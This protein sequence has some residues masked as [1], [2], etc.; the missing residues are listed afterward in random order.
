MRILFLM[1]DEGSPPG[2]LLEETQ[3]LG[4]QPSVLVP[5]KNISHDLELPGSVPT[6]PDGF[7]GLV[8]LG[9]AMSILD[10][11]D[12]P[13][14]D[15]TRH[16]F[17]AF[18]AA[19]KPVM[20][21]CFGAQLMADAHGGR[22][23]RLGHTE[24]GFLPQTWLPAAMDD[25]LLKESAPDL[26]LMQWHGDTFDLPDKAIPLSTRPDCPWQAFRIGE[27]NWGLQFHLELDQ[28]TLLKWAS[29]HADELKEDPAPHVAQM[30]ADIATY[31]K[32]Q[33]DF[34]RRVMRRWLDVCADA[35]TGR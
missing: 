30:H 19:R 8:V 3:A 34:A 18:D 17:R 11:A 23:K 6:T 27:I 35:K 21:V 13:F 28:P 14:V 5:Y 25:P 16:L 31:H 22:V 9:G 29:L 4:H 10:E 32:P 20:G 2:V 1:N 12:Y 7:D 26:P 15:Q 24:W 33:A